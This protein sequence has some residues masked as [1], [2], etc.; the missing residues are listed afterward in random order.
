MGTAGQRKCV[1]GRRIGYR[2]VPR[3]RRTF[4]HRGELH[5]DAADVGLQIGVV[6]DAHL[7]LH[8]R[9]GLL[10]GGNFLR[11]AHQIDL[12]LAGGGIRRARGDDDGEDGYEV[13]NSHL[14]GAPCQARTNA[15]ASAPL[16]AN[17]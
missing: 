11:L 10:A 5:A 3:Q 8:L 15:T 17:W 2:V 14:R 16:H 9:I 6:I 4:R 1:D 7:L 13:W 12:A